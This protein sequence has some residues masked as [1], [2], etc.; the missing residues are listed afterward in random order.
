MKARLAEL[1]AQ[2]AHARI[3]GAAAGA[4]ADLLQHLRAASELVIEA[5]DEAET[6]EGRAALVVGTAIGALRLWEDWV[7]FH[8]GSTE[9]DRLLEE[10]DELVI[11]ASAGPP[12]RLAVRQMMLEERLLRLLGTR[13]S[14]GERRHRLRIGC[15]LWIEVHTTARVAPGLVVNIGAG[16]ASVDSE[17]SVSRG[18]NVTLVIERQ[19]SVVDTGIAVRGTVAWARAGARPGFG[20]SFDEEHTPSG[21]V[22]I[23]RFVVASLRRRAVRAP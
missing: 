10:L 2:L 21:E 14:F 18:E 6:A 17:L 5:L 8:H 22:H 1:L 20:V 4:P 15:E 9:V 19:P 23:A 12:D 3:C 13:L 16:G 11:G 7:R